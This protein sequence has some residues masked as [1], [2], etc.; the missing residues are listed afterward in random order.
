VECPEIEAEIGHD[1]EITRELIINKASG[2]SFGIN[3]LPASRK[4]V[5]EAG[6]LI[7]YTRR[8]VLE[9]ASQG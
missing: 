1:L 4:A 3:P 8:R 9:Q 6:G 2:R 5:V 7:A